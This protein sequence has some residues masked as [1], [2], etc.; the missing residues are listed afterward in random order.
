MEPSMGAEMQERAAGTQSLV[1]PSRSPSQ[2]SQ[3][4]L[5]MADGISTEILKKAELEIQGSSQE[6]EEQGDLEESTAAELLTVTAESTESPVSA[7]LSPCSPPSPVASSLEVLVASEPQDTEERSVLSVQETEE[8]TLA[9][10]EKEWKSSI[11]QDLSQGEEV[12]DPQ[13]SQ[14]EEDITSSISDKALGPGNQE[15]AL[16]VP[17]EGPSSPSSMSTALAAEAARDLPSPAPAPL[18]PTEAE[19]AAPAPAGA[20]EEEEPQEP[21][22]AEETKAEGSPSVGELVPSAGTESPVPAPQSP[23][24]S[25][26]AL[27]DTDQQITPEILSEAELVMQGSDQQLE[28]QGDLEQATD[29]ETVTTFTAEREGSLVP[30]P[31][32]P[33]EGSQALL[34]TDQSSTSEFLSKAKLK[35]SGQDREEDLEQTWDTETV[36]TFTAEREGSLAPQSPCCTPSPS[37]PSLEAQALRE[38]E[39]GA[40]VGEG[41][42][43]KYYVDQEIFQWEDEEEQELSQEKNK[44]YQRVSQG[45][46]RSEQEPSPGPVRSHQELSDWDEYSEE[47]E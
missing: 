25:S 19:P 33:S 38:Q 42:D 35:G 39:E 37:A 4:L 13:L 47:E 43:W 3:A 8:G 6:L 12:R 15:D 23:S 44:T 22:A 18:S 21:L 17:Q 14:W 40:V 2:G 20:A 1:P 9:G 28:E 24:E 34:D 45:E 26:Q 7:P 27:L 29:T 36:S 30:T 31:L 16:A 5:D 11:D 10:E 46:E 32:S 41:Q